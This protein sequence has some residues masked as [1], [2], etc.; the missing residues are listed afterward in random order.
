MNATSLI[1]TLMDTFLWHRCLNI[2]KVIQLQSLNTTNSCHVTFHQEFTG[3][4][5]ISGVTGIRVFVCLV[6]VVNGEFSVHIFTLDFVFQARL[7]LRLALVPLHLCT[8]ARHLALKMTA[9]LIHRYLI[10]EFLHKL[11]WQFYSNNNT[12]SLKPPTW[13]TVLG[14]VCRGRHIW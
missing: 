12:K 4:F 6:Y 5:V 2:H 14:C 9:M 10:P 3:C 11:D 8:G 7:D 1:R 13:V